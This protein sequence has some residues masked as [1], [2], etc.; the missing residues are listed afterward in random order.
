MANTMTFLHEGFPWVPVDFKVDL[1]YVHT[2]NYGFLWVPMADTIIF[3][4]WGSLPG[5][6]YGYLWT[7]RIGF[8]GILC[9]VL[10]VYSYESLIH[11]TRVIIVSSGRWLNWAS[12]RQ[13]YLYE[14]QGYS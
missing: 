1:F 3:L 8:L 4:I 7:I 14:L 9:N 6:D 5:D 10:R 2:N 13:L 12:P 11:I